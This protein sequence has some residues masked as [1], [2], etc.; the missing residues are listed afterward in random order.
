MMKDHID[1]GCLPDDLARATLV[2]RAWCPDHDGPSVVAIRDGVVWDIT[3]TT[4][5]ASDLMDSADPAATARNADGVRLCTLDEL[6][7]N[8]D[9]TTR[10]HARP[11]PLAPIDLQS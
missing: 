2:G 1:S 8:A 4:P 7:A 5:T 10:D 11:W 3:E 6:L 9:E